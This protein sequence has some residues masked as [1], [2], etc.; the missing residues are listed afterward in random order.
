MKTTDW[1]ASHIGKRVRVKDEHDWVY[2][3]SSI[4]H[5][6]I[7][8]VLEARTIGV[9]PVNIAG[10]CFWHPLDKIELE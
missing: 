3:L 7:S 8:G 6:S 1:N 10:L 2:H 5:N 9:D 4:E